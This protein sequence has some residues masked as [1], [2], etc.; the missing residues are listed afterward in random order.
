[1]NE[2]EPATAKAS[3]PGYLARVSTV[4]QLLATVPLIV[5]M[6]HITAN[7]FARKF[8]G[9]P[10]ENTLELTQF[11]YLPLVVA[12]GYVLAVNTG[13]HTDAPIL[14]QFFS[15]AGKIGATVISG[16]VT[17]LL[18]FAFA[19]YTFDNALYDMEIGRTG[20][21]SG[22]V[23]WP[24]TFS[25]PIAF[26]FTGLLFA[27]QFTRNVRAMARGEDVE[28]DPGELSVDAMPPA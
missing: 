13:E 1:M 21:V 19:W 20:G 12:F 28:K 23:I 8:F 24:V 10:L 9:H 5:M 26:A 22:L 27:V 18:C 14:Y 25:M 11:W 15:P 7:A 3:A 2:T 6:V 16:V 17:V 4:V